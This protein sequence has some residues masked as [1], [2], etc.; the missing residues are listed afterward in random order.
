MKKVNDKLC[1]LLGWIVTLLVGSTVFITALQV[2]CRFVLK[3]PLFW[4]EPAA[5]YMFL[6]IIMLGLPV[7]YRSGGMIVFDLLVTRFPVKLQEAIAAV[8]NTLACAFF[9]YYGYQGIQL[10]IRAGAKITQGAIKIPTGY[11]YAAQPICAA[12]MLIIGIE[13]T[14]NSYRKL[15]SKEGGLVK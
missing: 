15:F 8:G 13:F 2:F 1:W 12:L 11:L 9:T 5:R 10:V 14:I 4:P 7:A 6:Y 3:N